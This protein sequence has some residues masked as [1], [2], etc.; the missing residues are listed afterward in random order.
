VI[1]IEFQS[2]ICEYPFSTAPFIKETVFSLMSI[3]GTFFMNQMAIVTLVYFWVSYAISLVYVSVFM[4]AV[5]C[6]V[7]KVL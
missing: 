7:N 1:G 6:F 4:P 3:F 2:S 5:G